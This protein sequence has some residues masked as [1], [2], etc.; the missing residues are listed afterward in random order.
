MSSASILVVCFDINSGYEEDVNKPLSENLTI[1]ENPLRIINEFLDIHLFLESEKIQKSSSEIKYSFNFNFSEENEILFDIVVLNDLS[2]IHDV[3]LEADAY[4]V[5]TNL[6]KEY[7]AEQLEKIIKY[8]LESCAMEKK[9]YLVGMYNDKILPTLNRETLESYFEEEK[10]NCEYY[11]IK[12]ED[13]I[14][15]N[16]YNHACMYQNR[17]DKNIKKERK[18]SFK[19]KQINNLIDIIELILI[20]IYETKM[21]VVYEPKK[22]IFKD[23]NSQK[24]YSISDSNSGTSGTNCIIF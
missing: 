24:D 4:L 12:C 21:N 8:I 14:K 1:L 5:F 18:N 17:T 16:E 15:N 9:T 22:N 19:K 23:Y 20:Q 3:S 2:Y 6:E 13:N 10:L 7:T 11:Q